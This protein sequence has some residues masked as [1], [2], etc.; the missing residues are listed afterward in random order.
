MLI[1]IF[2][3]VMATVIFC[4]CVAEGGPRIVDPAVYRASKHS[5]VAKHNASQSYWEE[6]GKSYRSS[7]VGEVT[8]GELRAPA[9]YMEGV[10][11]NDRDDPARFEISGD[12][13]LSIVVP[14]HNFAKAQ[15]PKGTYWLNIFSGRS[16]YPYRSGALKIDGQKGDIQMRG[17]ICDWYQLAP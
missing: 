7:G 9:L 2:A 17:I 5:I 11:F 16:S 6:L 13:S 4:G 15:L 14:P 8:S 12:F 10:L 3:V 1:R